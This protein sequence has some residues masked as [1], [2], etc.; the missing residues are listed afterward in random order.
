MRLG[1]GELM[2]EAEGMTQVVKGLP[3]Y[4]YPFNTTGNSSNKAASQSQ[5]DSMSNFS[6]NPK[7]HEQRL[8]WTFR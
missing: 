6:S 8:L 1:D 7:Y 5:E 4:R 2:I 3:E